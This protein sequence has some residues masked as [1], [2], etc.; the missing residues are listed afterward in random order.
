MSNMEEGEWC[1]HADP[2]ANSI[3]SRTSAPEILYRKAC[4]L[5]QFRW[6]VSQS[7]VHRREC[8]IG[9]GFHG[10]TVQLTDGFDLL[11]DQ[12]YRHCIS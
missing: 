1:A 11:A 5:S 10:A 3:A 8:A 9:I 7:F 4:P 6:S 12:R 2:A